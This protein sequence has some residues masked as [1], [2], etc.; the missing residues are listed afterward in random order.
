MMDW[1]DTEE[2][3]GPENWRRS[4]PVCKDA[5]EYMDTI[6][7]YLGGLVSEWCKYCI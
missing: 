3:L 1:N 5:H 4:K 6:N 7:H 2:Y